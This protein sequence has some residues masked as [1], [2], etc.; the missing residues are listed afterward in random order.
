MVPEAGA[1][2]GGRYRLARLL[3]QG[4]MGAVWLAH[5]T[6]GGQAVA[7]KFLSRSSAS[8]ATLRRFG[9]E[10]RALERLRVTNVVQIIGHGVDGGAPFI[11]ME[12]LVG[13]NLRSL[14]RRRGPLTPQQALD[15]LRQTAAGLA[16]AHALGIVHRDIK[17]SNLF[18][19]ASPGPI[20][21]VK[22]IDF[23]IATGE[24]IDGDSQASRTGLIGSPAYMSPEQ[25]RAEDVGSQADVW[26]L[27]VVAFQ[28][29]TGREPFAGAN[30]PETLE[31]VCSGKVPLPSTVAAGLP[32]R[33][34]AVFSC[35]FARERQN[36]FQDVD[37]L[38]AALD[39]AYDGASNRPASTSRSLG[40]AGRS[41]PTTSF[42]SNGR[43]ALTRFGHFRKRLGLSIGL[44]GLAAMG[45]FLA[46]QPASPSFTKAAAASTRS[47]PLVSA[48]SR[49]RSE[50]KPENA[51]PSVSQLPVAPPK[52]AT[53][54]PPALQPKRRVE[55]GPLSRPM[56]SA[57]SALTPAPPTPPV[58]HDPI[59]GLPV[60]SP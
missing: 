42:G 27:S 11:A 48:V 49:L 54:R 21:T 2:V 19:C 29:L 34:D 30:V 28:M 7:V 15:I 18:I 32:A 57:S 5:D 52:A 40:K 58:E 16:A 56:A 50:Q 3:D 23:G 25:A 53:P 60:K 4:G 26:S 12:L 39:Q 59:F 51:V 14:L 8:R 44:L 10:A 47:P 43:A 55:N 22:I 36:R 20:G 33:L 13:E 46:H 6:R 1:V 9:R 24:V 38:I 31:R 17:P 45:S 37:A 41:T 35:A